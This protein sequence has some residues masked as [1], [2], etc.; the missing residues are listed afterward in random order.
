MLVHLLVAVLV[1][2]LHLWAAFA[3]AECPPWFV[4]G[5]NSGS[6]PQCVCSPYVPFMIDC[7]QKEYVVSDSWTLCVSYILSQ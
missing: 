3:E 6:S 7:V 5:N 4:S 1:S 2:T